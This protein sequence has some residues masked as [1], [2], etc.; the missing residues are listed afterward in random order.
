MKEGY[1]RQDL[2]ATQ[3]E[4]DKKKQD[5]ADDQQAI[6]DLEDDLRQSGGDPGWDREEEPAAAAAT[7]ATPAS[8]EAAEPAAGAQP[9]QSGE[10][11]TPSET[12]TPPPTPAPEPST[13]P[14]AN[15]P[16]TAP[17]SN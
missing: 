17:P 14:D 10:V 3:A 13:P 1:T 8:P 16:A 4:I 2:D 9:G 6:S 11:V 7:P 15:A 5:V 12:S